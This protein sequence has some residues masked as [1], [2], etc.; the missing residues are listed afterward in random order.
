MKSSHTLLCGG[1][2]MGLSLAT[3]ASANANEVRLADNTPAWAAPAAMNPDYKPAGKAA[4]PAAAE[5]A[6]PATGG[7]ATTSYYG[8]SD[9][10]KNA[11]W[12]APA[13]MN[14]DYKKAATTVATPTAAP[15]SAP[16]K[17]TRNAAVEACSSAIREAAAAAKLYFS[18]GSASL[19][20][21]AAAA[22]KA[23]ATVAKGCHDVV[24]EVAG[25]TDS[26]GSPDANKLL[27]EQRANS[28]VDYLKQSGVDGSKLKAIGMGQENPITTNDTPDG[29]RLNRRIEFTVTG[30]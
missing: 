27:S 2:F 11:P 15:T 4:A 24:I 19:E 10:S 26:T 3:A 7:T 8:G 23:V 17:I 1:V 6:P 25:H 16:T 18:N 13:S 28:V 20:S 21:G 14:P 12:A 30:H 5:T 9:T 29:R 22:L